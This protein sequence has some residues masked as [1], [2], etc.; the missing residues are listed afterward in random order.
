MISRPWTIS[1]P[2]I[3]TE[4][5]PDNDSLQAL[6]YEGCPV[7]LFE[8]GAFVYLTDPYEEPYTKTQAWLLPIAHWLY[9][10]QG[11]DCSGWVRFDSCGDV[12]STLP[13][14]DWE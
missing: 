11:P 8:E 10:L 7:A 5:C 12:I 2:V 3:S 6:A 9:D 1:V 4:H 13:T 14:F